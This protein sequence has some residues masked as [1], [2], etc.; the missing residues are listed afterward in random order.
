MASSNRII[1]CN[2]GIPVCG[3]RVCVCVCVCVCLCVFAR[4]HVC[5]RVYT[6][7]GHA[8]QSRFEILQSGH[9]SCVFGGEC[10]S[11]IYFQPPVSFSTVVLQGGGRTFSLGVAL[12]HPAA[13]HALSLGPAL[14]PGLSSFAHALHAERR[15][16][17]LC[18]TT[19]MRCRRCAPPACLPP[20]AKGVGA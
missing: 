2:A 5:A 19:A 11:L 6:I 1:R 9:H 3:V 20:C 10:P 4:A 15:C 8:V 12:L 7:V 17:L 13:R 14:P 18:S 16:W